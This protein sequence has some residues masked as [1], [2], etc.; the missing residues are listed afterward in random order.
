MFSLPICFCG[1][2]IACVGTGDTNHLTEALKS[3]QVSIEVVKADWKI[4]GES[5]KKDNSRWGKLK[6]KLFG[7]KSISLDPD[8][9]RII[10]MNTP[11]SLYRDYYIKMLPTYKLV[12]FMWEPLMHGRKMYNKN[13]HA[14]MGRVYTWDDD[15]VDN[16]HYFKF[17]YPVLTSMIDNIPSFEEKNFCTMISGYHSSEKFPKK[18]PNELYTERKKQSLSL[19]K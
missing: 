17:Y 1:K 7:D 18:Y 13:L 15:L 5:F 12:L 14:C 2:E 10:F 9:K 8:I 3:H 6:R 16:I 19:S 11:P 4:F